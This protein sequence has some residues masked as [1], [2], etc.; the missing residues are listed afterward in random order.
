MATRATIH[1][2]KREEGVS[3][4]EKPDKLLEKYG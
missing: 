3:F 1:V 2:A 4:S